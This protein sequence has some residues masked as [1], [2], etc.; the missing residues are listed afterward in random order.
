MRNACKILVAKFELKDLLEDLG[1]GGKIIFKRILKK[2]GVKWIEVAWYRVQWHKVLNLG[3]SI[4][5][6]EFLT[7]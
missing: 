3:G 4:K 7:R 2:L 1:V 5:G 6:G